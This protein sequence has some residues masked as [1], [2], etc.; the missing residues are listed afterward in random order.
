MTT[1]MHDNRGLADR[2]MGLYRMADIGRIHQTRDRQASVKLKAK[3]VQPDGR[4]LAEI[5]A[6]KLA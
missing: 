6:M 4:A 1:E 5:L 2:T 3:L